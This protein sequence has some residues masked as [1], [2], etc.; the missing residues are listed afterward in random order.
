MVDRNLTVALPKVA[1]L[2]ES[3][4][5]STASK[6]QEL[7]PNALFTR[8]RS[9]SISFRT[10][11]ISGAQFQARSRNIRVLHACSERAIISLDTGDSRM[12]TGYPKNSDA[13]ATAR[14]PMAIFETTRW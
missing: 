9:A 12:A 14:Q 4:A 1:T 11:L 5:F 8:I 2:N 3:S 7:T 13:I 10:A 6:R